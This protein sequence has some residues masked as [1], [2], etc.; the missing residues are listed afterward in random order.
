M[1]LRVSYNLRLFGIGPRRTDRRGVQPVQR[2]EPGRLQHVAVHDGRGAERRP[3]CSRRRSPATSR[4]ANSASG[5][6]GSGSV[7]TQPVGWRLLEVPGTGVLGRR[8]ARVSGPAVFFCGRQETGEH[9]RA[10]QPWNWNCGN[11]NSW[12]RQR[13]SEASSCVAALILP[14][15]GRRS[16]RALGGRPRS[17]CRGC[18]SPDTQ[19]P[20]SAAPRRSAAN[21]ASAC[22]NQRIGVRRAALLHEQHAEA[23]GGVGGPRV[24]LERRA[25]R[26]LPRARA[27]AGVAPRVAQVR[28]EGGVRG[29]VL[30]RRART[31]PPPPPRCPA[32]RASGRG[33][34]TRRRWTAAAPARPARRAPLRRACPRPPPRPRGRDT[35]PRPAASAR[36]GGGR[37]RPPAARVP[38]P[39]ARARRSPGRPARRDRRGPAAPGRAARRAHPRPTARVSSRSKVFHAAICLRGIRGAG[40]RGRGAPPET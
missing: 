39:S 37:S 3:S 18:R 5:S 24:A 31:P 13:A 8:L 35:A 32:R 15:P 6:S 7:L 36:P 28:P 19:S 14:R 40:V 25:V 38:C 4:R 21:P 22:S 29:I 12:N 20:D 30:R 1:N 26:L 16:R 27:I 34:S 2:Q 23:V 17:P 10:G 11:W 33:R 9:A